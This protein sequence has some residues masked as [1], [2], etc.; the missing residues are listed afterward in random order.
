MKSSNICLNK[1]GH[2]I[3]NIDFDGMIKEIF[4][5]G[6]YDTLAEL[7]KF[8]KI[9][10]KVLHDMTTIILDTIPKESLVFWELIENIVSHTTTD[11]KTL[12]DIFN[13][14][15]EYLAKTSD[16]RGR[17]YNV[18]A[19]IA[20]HPNSTPELIAKLGKIDIFDVQMRLA[21]NAAV[22]DNY[23]YLMIQ[24]ESLSKDIRF[25]AA[26]KL[27]EKHKETIKIE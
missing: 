24:N 11:E 10:P 12:G 21:T 2:F 16:I 9:T 1:Y 19:C 6:D 13:A 18:L 7:T 26:K 25:E 27:I 4:E 14:M 23:L 5:D 8:Y 3:K 15:D 22:P 17:K 20:G